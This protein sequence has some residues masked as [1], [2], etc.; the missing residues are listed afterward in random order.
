TNVGLKF[1]VPRAAALLSPSENRTNVGLKSQLRRLGA[2]AHAVARLYQGVPPEPTTPPEPIPEPTPPTPEPAG[3]G[4]AIALL[5]AKGIVEPERG[6]EILPTPAE[7]IPQA[8][9]GMEL[10]EAAHKALMEAYYTQSLLPLLMPP[11]GYT[12]QAWRALL[13][14]VGQRLPLVPEV[15]YFPNWNEAFGFSYPPSWDTY[16]AD[17]LPIPVGGLYAEYIRSALLQAGYP[18]PL[19]LAFTRFAECGY[20]GDAADAFKLPVSELISFSHTAYT[21]LLSRGLPLL[22]RVLEVRT[23]VLVPLPEALPPS[24]RK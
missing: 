1:A 17:G 9:A 11:A 14:H 22:H 19:V 5:A 2:A 10:P 3:I 15:M 13:F 21:A 6:Y 12:W 18:K 4:E 20:V 24:V 16:K 23:E 8:I 7:L